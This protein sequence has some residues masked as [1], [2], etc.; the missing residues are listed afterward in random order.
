M[1]SPVIPPSPPPSFTA[2]KPVRRAST[3][4]VT[5][6]IPGKSILKKPPPAP[7]GLLSR[8]TGGSFGKF[9]GAPGP[10]PSPLDP[11]PGLDRNN[12]DPALK[13]AHF[14]LPHIAVVYPISSAAPPRTPTTQV[15]KRAIEERERERRRRVV[16]GES[17]GTPTTAAEYHYGLPSEPRP[18]LN[19]NV[20]WSMD[21]VEAFYQ[22]C[23]AACDEPPDAAIS[24]A[25]LRSSSAALTTLSTNSTT[26]TTSPI[27][28]STVNSASSTPAPRTLDLTGISLS[29]AQ[30][31]ILADVLSIEWG[32]RTLVLCESNLDATVLKPIL[33]ALLLNNTLIF[34][35]VASNA[36]LAAKST[37]GRAGA[38]YGLSLAGAGGFKGNGWL[39]LEAYLARS[40]LKVLDLSRNVLDKRA[41]EGV[42]RGAVGASEGS[43][44]SSSL[45]SLTLDQS[46]LKSTALDVLARAVR[47]S[48]S[49]RTLSLRNCRIGGLGSRGGIAVSLMVRDWPDS[50][51][52][53]VNQS[54]S[55]IGATLSFPTVSSTLNRNRPA[56]LDLDVD[57]PP[58]SP[59]L[60][61]SKPLLPPPTHPP[62]HQPPPTHPA[63]P[64]SA[65]VGTTYTPYVP[66]SKRGVA[67]AT[68]PRTA[69]PL[70]G[71]MPLTPTLTTISRGGVT[72]ASADL[73]NKVVHGPGPAVQVG[74][75][76]I[77]PSVAALNSASAALLSQVRAL[78][79]LPRI[80]SLRVLDLRGNELR[81]NISPLAQVLKRNRTLKSLNLQDNKIDPKGLVVI[82]EAL[83]YNACL[84]ELDLGRNP[85][86]GA[87]GPQGVASTGLGSTVSSSTLTVSRNSLYTPAPT[88]TSSTFK[89]N[90]PYPSS[91]SASTSTPNSL[92]SNLTNLALEGIYALRLALALNTTLTRLSLSATHLGDSGAIAL[93]EWMG[94]YK[95]L[96]WLDLTRNASVNANAPPSLG[97]AGV[98]LSFNTGLG[99]AG[100]MALAQ[101]VKVNRILRC[102]D[103]EVPP[104]VEGYARLSR[105]ILN[106]CIRNV[107]A[108]AKEK[109]EQAD[110]HRARDCVVALRKALDAI[111]FN[112]VD[113]EFSDAGVDTLLQQSKTALNDLARVISGMLDSNNN[114]DSGF[115]SGSEE[116]MQEVLQ[117]SD[118]LGALVREV[119]QGNGKPA[120]SSITVGETD[121]EVGSRE[122]P[123]LRVQVPNLNSTTPNTV[124]SAPVVLIDSPLSPLSGDS[125]TPSRSDKGKA[126]APPEPVRHEPVLSPTAVLLRNGVRGTSSLG[127]GVGGLGLPSEDEDGMGEGDNGDDYE[128]EEEGEGEGEDGE[129]MKGEFGAGVRSRSWVAEEGEVFRKGNA[130]LGPEE[131]EGEYAGEDL[132]RE[133]LEAMVERPAP[134]SLHLDDVDDYGVPISSS[135]PLLSPSTPTASS[136]PSTPLAP[137]PEHAG[138]LSNG[139]GYPFSLTLDGPGFA[140]SGGTTP[141][142]ELTSVTSAH[143][144]RPYTPRTRSSSAVSP[145]T[146]GSVSGPQNVLDDQDALRP[147]MSR[148]ESVV[149]ESI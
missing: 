41:M 38:G 37:I 115:D 119:E 106:T 76:P 57:S 146:N 28:T 27:T 63:H 42:V 120:P 6:P 70:S 20:W 133:L 80:G 79:A 3:S 130:L 125:P 36:G 61:T 122:K 147:H 49:L 78:D 65:K 108:S 83:K 62:T 124:P 52:S 43:S 14:I 56:A 53:S 4:S 129:E 128:D 58:A 90:A 136:G 91:A 99:E 77:P 26:T 101:G 112:N 34:L 88:P 97:S 86:C 40:N 140:G 7:T 85:C 95:G 59:L 2:P 68:T 148:S 21:K 10:N 113:P 9:F 141:T 67:G 22:E 145:Q 50:V 29:P 82:A 121:D 138:G 117:L 105:E 74:A 75:S 104:G 109:S 96:K 54:H 23:C 71:N 18:P 87:L 72:A 17:V 55:T 98:A 8:L 32:L 84:D 111:A 89:T 73:V 107:E 114:P 118:E 135:T 64:S 69:T 60:P 1:N 149:G 81:S 33:H 12:S 131:M 5:I 100:V 46:T 127:L 102:L 142:Q 11:S 24:N 13:R 30:A 15:E 116:Q 51:G 16:W 92:P 66:R 94:E 44:S 137:L 143:S 39:V 132:R 110:V 103:V 126:R 93:A 139:N 123:N 25:L 144:S 31:E 48:P 47:T 134:R 45:I 19:P 35:S